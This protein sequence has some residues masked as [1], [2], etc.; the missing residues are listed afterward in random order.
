MKSNLIVIDN[1]NCNLTIKGPNIIIKELYKEYIVI[2]GN[3]TDILISKE[4][5]NGRS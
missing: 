3:I 4:D 1:N 5:I 2:S